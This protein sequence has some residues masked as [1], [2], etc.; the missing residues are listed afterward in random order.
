MEL[1]DES[2]FTPGTTAGLAPSANRKMNLLTGVPISC[3]MNNYAIN[4]IEMRKSDSPKT[5][6]FL[7]HH[8]FKLNI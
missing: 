2:N 7:L 3:A 5:N 8:T 6:T 4:T 1:L